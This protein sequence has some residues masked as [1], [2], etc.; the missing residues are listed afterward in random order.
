MSSIGTARRS[1]AEWRNA[2]RG[3]LRE[4]TMVV[5]ETGKCTGCGSCQKICHEHCMSLVHA[6]VTI[7]FGACSTCAQRI[8]I[9]PEKALSW[10]GVFPGDRDPR[11]LPTASHL[12]EH[13]K[14]FAV[15]GF[16]HPSVTFRNNVFGRKMNLQWNDG[17]HTKGEEDNGST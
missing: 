10:D 15:A 14:I 3:E 7:D 8:A 5:I 13:E 12:D 6:R 17:S 2:A 9:C 1:Q 11:L 4:R 16:G